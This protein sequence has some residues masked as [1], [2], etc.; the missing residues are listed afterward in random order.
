MIKP[1]NAHKHRS[2][3]NLSDRRAGSRRAARRAD[4]HHTRRALKVAKQETRR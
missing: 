1:R 4:R 2:E 3:A